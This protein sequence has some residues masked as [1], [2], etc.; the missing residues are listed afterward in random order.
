LGG[1]IDNPTKPIDFSN[2]NI[3]NQ[4][5]TQE[6]ILQEFQKEAGLLRPTE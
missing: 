2:S 6:Q 5:K 3:E 1:L 4:H